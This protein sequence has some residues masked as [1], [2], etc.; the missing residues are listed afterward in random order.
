MIDIGPCEIRTPRQQLQDME[1]IRRIEKERIFQW[2][3]NGM[4]IEFMIK[5]LTEEHIRPVSS[6]E[7]G[8]I[9][10]AQ[11]VMSVAKTIVNVVHITVDEYRNKPFAGYDERGLYCY[12]PT[13][14]EKK[15]LR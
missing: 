4:D 13:L 8:I 12:E 1:R 7:N 11:E 5:K 2:L 6:T 15:K 3:R 9:R 14:E 10:Y